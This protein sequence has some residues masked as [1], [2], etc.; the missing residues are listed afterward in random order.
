MFLRSEIRDAELKGKMKES[1]ALDYIEALHGIESALLEL[2]K[3]P[4]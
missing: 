2:K 4:L 3:K 1:V